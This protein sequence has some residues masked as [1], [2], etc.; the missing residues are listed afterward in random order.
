VTGACVIRLFASGNDPQPR[1]QDA[2]AL[3][4]LVWAAVDDW[5]DD[6]V[7]AGAANAAAG[8]AITASAARIV[9]G[10]MW[11]MFMMVFPPCE[12]TYLDDTSC[13]LVYFLSR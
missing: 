1:G 13:Q 3:A 2:T 6:P 8:T 9:F 10:V 7:S 5:M 4:E 11:W 12:D